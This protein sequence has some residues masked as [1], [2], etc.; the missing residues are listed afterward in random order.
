[1]NKCWLLADLLTG[2][3]LGANFKRQLSEQDIVIFHGLGAGLWYYLS[4]FY[5]HISQ[6][7]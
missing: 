5:H 1:M 7:L 6:T 2:I 4:F 3:L